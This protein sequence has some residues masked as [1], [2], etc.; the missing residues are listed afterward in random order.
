M[1]RRQWIFFL[2]LNILVSALVTSAI[3]YFYDRSHRT[4]SSISTSTPVKASET[5]KVDIVSVIGAGTASSE[6]VVI[7]N[8]DANSFNLNGWM[9]K[10]GNGQTYTFPSFTIYSDATVQV[11]TTSGNDTFSDV[12]W[13]LTTSVWQSGE[14]ATLYDPQNNARGSYRVP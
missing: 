9:L 2:F 6:V 13:D 3:L 10:N 11:H 4:S 5:V 8:N 12:Y 1:N 14:T 7:K